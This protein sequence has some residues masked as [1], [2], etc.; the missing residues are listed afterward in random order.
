M[1]AWD[2]AV[3]WTAVSAIGMVAVAAIHDAWMGRSQ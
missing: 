2:F 3:L 1:N